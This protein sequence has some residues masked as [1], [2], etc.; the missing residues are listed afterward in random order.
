MAAAQD[1][2]AAASGVP[3]RL[4]E[5]VVPVQPVK[6][7]PVPP[8][9]GQP[10]EDIEIGWRLWER[11]S[12]WEKEIACPEFVLDVVRYGYKLPFTRP[13]PRVRR[14]NSKVCEVHKEFVSGA[15]SELV[16]QGCMIEV[17][18][19]PWVVCGLS[20]DDSRESL[21]L[22][23]D[24]RPVNE[25]LFVES[26][27]YETVGTARDFL[28]SESWLFQF[29]VKSAYPHVRVHPD[30][31]GTLGVRWQGKWY[32]YC[33]LPFGLAT[34]PFV[35]TKVM[36]VLLGVWRSQGIHV[37]CMLD[38]GLGGAASQVKARH[39]SA[40]VRETLRR[41][42]L[43]EHI[44]KSV[45]EPATATN[46][47]LGFRID[48][49]TGRMG[50]KIARGV[51]VMKVLAELRKDVPV[52][53]RELASVAGRI[54]S[55]SGVLGNIVRL[56]TR[57][58]F[59]MIGEGGES[60]EVRLVWSGG[61]WGEV[62]FWRAFAIRGGFEMTS[63]F[64]PRQLAVDMVM[65]S[66]A[67]DS[68]VGVVV[69]SASTG[70]R[71]SFFP[72]SEEEQLR[73]ST[74][75]E[76]EAVRFGVQAFS[77]AV[78]GRVVRWK[79]DNQAAVSILQK[80]SKVRELQQLARA[81][82]EW[83]RVRQITLVPLWVPREE[84]VEA[85]AMSRCVDLNDWGM[86]KEATDRMQEHWGEFAVD[87]FADTMNTKCAG[88]FAQRPMPGAAG[89]DGLASP[90]PTGLLYACPPWAL[91]GRLLRRLRE[92]GG[93]AV[94]VVPVWPQQPWWPTV[95][96]DGAHTG[97]RVLSALTLRRDDFAL[98]PSGRPGFIVN[99]HWKFQA[100]A[101]RWSATRSAMK[102][103]FCLRKQRGEPCD[104]TTDPTQA[105]A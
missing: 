39:D 79:T 65:A 14:H 73:S 42:G 24:A 12:Y 48:L 87:L 93:E 7:W 11:R 78:K 47:F 80:G 90:W 34:A 74:W 53:R 89:V 77:A 63:A 36:R 29:D 1:G 83:C 31:W 45:W 18:E 15:I 57:E 96:P 103:A 17:S 35:F 27:K 82:F 40:V 10:L 85:D 8:P 19:C 91:L 38:D 55:M 16:T 51:K 50:I 52:R 97:P 37:M 21:R 71:Q 88:F 4:V 61:A 22:I 43:T 99:S 69:E 9:P 62:R 33:V 104:C 68:A 54:V 5:V 32:V 6:G 64:W 25:C 98:G 28:S 46:A 30:H 23:F 100:L 20:V 75:R 92:E 94:L 72:L 26:F 76:L 2:A 102:P 84:N 41:A 49:P 59:A 60:W 56:M 66:D 70:P 81:I 95:F 58:M 3:P 101:L 86:K 44:G 13:P 67:S 105:Q